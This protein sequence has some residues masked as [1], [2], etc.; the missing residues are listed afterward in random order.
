MKLGI[1]IRGTVHAITNAGNLRCSNETRIVEYREGNVA[2]VTCKNCIQN[3]WTRFI[4]ET[5]RKAFRRNREGK[6]LHGLS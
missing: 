4:E 2:E 6:D 3:T 1:T 5:K